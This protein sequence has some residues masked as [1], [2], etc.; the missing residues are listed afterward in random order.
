VAKM[1]LGAHCLYPPRDCT[2]AALQLGG[3][4]SYSEMCP[5]FTLL[6]GLLRWM[7][8]TTSGLVAS[9][10]FMSRVYLQLMDCMKP[11]DCNAFGKREFIKLIRDDAPLLWFP[12]NFPCG[13][14]A[15]FVDGSMSPLS[16]VVFKDLSHKF[17]FESA[18][19]KI[20]SQ[21]YDDQVAELFVRKGIC[22]ACRAQEGMYGT[23]GAPLLGDRKILSQTCDCKDVGFGNFVQDMPGLVRSSPSLVD[24]LSLLRHFRNEYSIIDEESEL[25]TFRETGKARIREEVESTLVS[26]S[27]E[28]WKCFNIENCLHP[29]SPDALREA[30]QIFQDEPLLLALSGGFVLSHDSDMPALVV[31]NQAMFECFDDQFG[32]KD[33]CLIGGLSDQFVKEVSLED[34]DASLDSLAV[35][36]RA[37]M[38]LPPEIFRKQTDYL[39]GEVF[40]TPSNLL[41]LMKFLEIPSLSEYVTETSSFSKRT[42]DATNTIECLNSMLRLVQM[43]WLKS[44]KTYLVDQLAVSTRIRA[45]LDMKVYGCEHLS[46]SLSLDIPRLGVQARKDNL[47]RDFYHDCSENILLIS[48]E[49]KYDVRRDLCIGLV[50]KAVKIEVALLERNQC[51]DLIK[52]LDQMLRKYSRRAGWKV[53]DIISNY[54][55]V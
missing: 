35:S 39:P 52:P 23:R 47:T 44:E 32:D 17:N 5:E 1:K 21:Y 51:L 10:A 18:P 16:S 43:Y 38:D 8:A 28:I 42:Y 26:M 37:F 55:Y 9:V 24:M 48:H 25:E 29:Y 54:M 6:T 36:R 41:P 4:Q 33:V 46:Y 22:C 27:K 19:V 2:Q 30:K 34:K 7:S 11:S 49:C 31:D 14:A 53:R 3:V 45:L 50:M 13:D 12:M 20:L 15:A 40:F